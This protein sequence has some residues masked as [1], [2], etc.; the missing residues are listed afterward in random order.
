MFTD[1]SD[2]NQ[3]LKD[4]PK[5]YKNLDTQGHSLVA[6]IIITSRVPKSIAE[7]LS[8]ATCQFVREWIQSLKRTYSAQWMITCKG[9]LNNITW[10]KRVS[11]CKSVSQAWSRLRQNHSLSFAYMPLLRGFL[12]SETTQKLQA[13]HVLFQ[14]SLQW[15]PHSSWVFLD[16]V[17]IMIFS[18]SYLQDHRWKSIEDTFWELVYQNFYLVPY[19]FF[20]EGYWL[21]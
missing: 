13:I 11:T 7:L 19:G 3:A 18:S 1:L 16:E 12:Y 5:P 9:G 6:E 21:L 4:E 8:K 2:R 14:C 17:L 15:V 10:S 20:V